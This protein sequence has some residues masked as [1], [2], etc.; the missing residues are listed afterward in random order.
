[1][2]H[3]V[4]TALNAQQNNR[5][6]PF[7]IVDSATDQ[8]IG[9]TRYRDIALQHFRLEMGT[10]CLTPTHQRSHANTEAKLLL[11]GFAFENLGIQ[12]VVFKTR[13]LNDPSRRALTRIGAV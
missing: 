4:L 13:V 9:N 8:V 11:L 5:G 2:H 10:T 6:L 3:Y 1:M 7:V 12:R